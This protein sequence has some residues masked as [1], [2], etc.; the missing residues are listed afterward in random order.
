MCPP[1][2]F[3]VC[4]NQNGYVV[5]MLIQMIFVFVE[6][7][8]SQEKRRI[9]IQD[10]SRFS[11]AHYTGR[12]TYDSKSMPEKNRDYLPPEIIETLRNSE[13]SVVSNLFINKLNRG[14]NLMS[15]EEAKSTKFRFMSKVRIRTIF[16]PQYK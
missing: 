8:Y 6:N 1:D 13:N 9:E 10:H 7:L 3:D 4:F 12:V 14:G 11:V 16:I 2:Y 15:A 5:R